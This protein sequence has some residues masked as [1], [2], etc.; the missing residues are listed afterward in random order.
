MKCLYLAISIGNKLIGDRCK[1]AIAFVDN[2]GL[3][4]L[5]FFAMVIRLFLLFLLSYVFGEW[6]PCNLGVLY[7]DI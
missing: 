6:V 1:F 2:I 3:F 4:Q 5:P 7:L